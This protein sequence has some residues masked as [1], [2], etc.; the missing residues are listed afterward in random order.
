MTLCLVWRSEKRLHMASDSRISFGNAGFVDVG[1]K[2]MRLPV[3]VQGTGGDGITADILLRRQY[4]FCYAGSL[5]NAA[6]FRALIED[7]LD[8]VQFVHAEHEFAFDDLCE[9]VRHYC[10]KISTTVC[11]C[12]YENGRYEFILAGF[13]PLQSRL[14]AA[15]FTFEHDIGVANAGYSEVAMNEGDFEALGSGREEALKL[16]SHVD[17]ESMLLV[18]NQIIDE[19]HVESV[20][21]DIQY[22]SFDK[23]GD[24]S[25]SGITRISQEHVNDG[26][27]E[28]GPEELKIFKY[29]G[30]QMYEGWQLDADKF[31][32]TPSFVELSVPSND[33]SAAYFLQKCRRDVESE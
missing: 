27:L 24:F 33:E 25:V 1:V 15:K 17:V 29:R 22:G 7:L 3:C 2:V 11:S 21:G 19:G 32:P 16:I 20:G 23:E 5:A 6:T 26:G 10:S 18:I 31:W 30:F 12:L 14:R 8:R 13:C 4:G 28:Y 9:F